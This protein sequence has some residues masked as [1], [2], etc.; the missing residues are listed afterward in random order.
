MKDFAGILSNINPVLQNI[1]PFKTRVI[2][3]RIDYDRKNRFFGENYILTTSNV[4]ALNER[5]GLFFAETTFSEY[6]LDITISE[7]KSLQEQ[8]ASAIAEEELNKGASV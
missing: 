8:L 5:D 2:I 3:G 4:Q 6:Q 1:H 7:F